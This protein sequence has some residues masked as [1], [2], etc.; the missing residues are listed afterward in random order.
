MDESLTLEEVRSLIERGELKRG[1]MLSRGGEPN[2]N[3]ASTFSELAQFFT[4]APVAP[5]RPLRRFVAKFAEV[6]KRSEIPFIRA[7]AVVWSAITLAI[8]ISSGNGIAERAD[9]ARWPATTASAVNWSGYEYRVG[10]NSYSGSHP[11]G[12]LHRGD[13]FPV[14]YDPLNPAKSRVESDLSVDP[15]DVF[16][17]IAVAIAFAAG[18]FAMIK[19]AATAALLERWSRDSGN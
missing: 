12:Y 8:L 9:A 16:G 1:D 10:D 6:Q 18:V 7:F 14:R 4:H 11:E 19:P 3:R 15:E 17:T 13:Q 2:W 5:A